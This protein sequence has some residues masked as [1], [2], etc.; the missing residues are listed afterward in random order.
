M[1]GGRKGVGR[2]GGREGRR[3]G[4]KKGPKQNNKNKILQCNG[5]ERERRDPG[6]V[7]SLIRRT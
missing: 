6:F 1:E 5:E 2:V 3:E 4:R 7:P